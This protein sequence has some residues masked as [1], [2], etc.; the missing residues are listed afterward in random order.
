MQLPLILKTC[1][2]GLKNNMGI[3]NQPESVPQ[4][5]ELG[6]KT[7]DRTPPEAGGTTIIM[8]RH[9]NYDRETGRLSI[10]GQKDSL[11]HSKELLSEM[12]EKIP[13]EER[14]K[15]TIFV[16][17]SPTKKNEG[18]RS[19]ET[20]KAVIESAQ[21]IFDSFGI[22]REN[23]LTDQ[24]MR[25]EDIEEPRIFKGD[26]KFR[27][28]LVERYGLGSKDFWKAFEEDEHKKEREEM[29]SEGPAEIADRFAR[30][31]NVL[32]RFARLFHSKNKKE[33]KR[34]IIWN[35]SH[36]DT[37]S[38]F[39]KNYVA[40]RPL[41]E[42][43][44]VGYDGGISLLISP[45]NEASITINGESY[46]IELPESGTALPRKNTKSPEK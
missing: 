30:F 3:E 12:L 34:L 14:Q 18:E 19:I 10:D 31:A 17:A 8:Q 39:T 29:G 42:H 26:N 23:I 35:V 38:P 44:P 1:I 32:A 25:V 45:E 16:V 43:I 37:I 4:K 5:I 2:W 46:P 24:P 11:E 22:P 20:A 33:G 40:G 28:F 9:G 7:I 21:S 15:V 41:E 6:P 36:Y 27:K 13:P